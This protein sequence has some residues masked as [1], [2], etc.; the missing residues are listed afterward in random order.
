MVKDILVCL[1]G[2]P[3]SQRATEVGIRVGRDLEAALVGLAIVD[4]PNIRASEAVGIGGASFKQQRDEA[5]LA[6]AHQRAQ[7]WL[8]AFVAR[9]RDAGVSVRTLELTGRP[10]PVILEEMQRHDLTLLGRHANFRF[11]TEE[12]D[13][14]TRDH[15]LRRAGKPVVIVPEDVVE[16]GPAVLVAYDQ[17]PAADRALRS[18]A[19]SGLARGRAVHVASVADD[20][21]IAWD[22]AVRGC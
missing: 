16:A 5:L 2:S 22:I 12:Q 4:E 11:E 13:L 10:G 14:Q 21:A 18:F 20:A 19:A 8:D 15:V 1:E 17:S 7:E 3:S 6:D 9:C